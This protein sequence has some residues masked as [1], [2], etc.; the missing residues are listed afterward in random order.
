MSG[1][2]RVARPVCDTVGSTEADWRPQPVGCAQRQTATQNRASRTV[3]QNVERPRP[4]SDGEF[5]DFAGNR[6]RG[7]RRHHTVVEANEGASYMAKRT[8]TP[9]RSD[10]GTQQSAVNIT[11]APTGEGPVTTTPTVA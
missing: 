1:E 8:R 9:G 4:S 6:N 5:L 7:A 2:S 3:P 11:P 10:S